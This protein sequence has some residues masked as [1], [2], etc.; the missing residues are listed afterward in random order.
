[1]LM[2]R[3]SLRAFEVVCVIF[4]AVALL[5]PQASAF[6]AR[7]YDPPPPDYGKVI[8]RSPVV[9]LATA[10]AAWLKKKKENEEKAVKSFER[11]LPETNDPDAMRK[12]IADLKKDI[13]TIGKEID[14]LSA[15][16]AFNPKTNRKAKANA[17][18]VIDNAKAWSATLAV[19]AATAAESDTKE[20]AKLG[21]D[22]AAIDSD[23]KR[24]GEEDE[25]FK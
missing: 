16:D 4:A 8:G 17:K 22:A 14:E 9:R 21:K 7:L 6:D 15:A 24:A 10:K 1:M 5:C 11:Q 2:S 13:E 3:R 25:L 20:A 18:L 12:D 23:L 19:Q